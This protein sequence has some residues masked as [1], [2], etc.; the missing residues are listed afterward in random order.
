MTDEA[1]IESVLVNTFPQTFLTRFLGPT[2]KEREKK[3]AI[4]SMASYYS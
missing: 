3:S 4:I 1:V 2:M